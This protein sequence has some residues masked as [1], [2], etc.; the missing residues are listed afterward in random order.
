VRKKIALSLVVACAAIA[1]ARCDSVYDV[2]ITMSDAAAARAFGCSD[3]SGLLL[4]RLYGKPVTIVIDVIELGTEV[5]SCRGTEIYDY[6]ATHE[7]KLFK[8]DCHQVTVTQPSSFGDALAQ[9]FAQLRKEDAGISQIPTDQTIIVKLVATAEPLAGCPVETLD[10]TQVGGC[11][12][13]CP[14]KLAASGTLDLDLDSLF[15]SCAPVVESCAIFPQE[16]ADF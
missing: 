6:C 9:T 2:T 14:T 16:S 7:C 12:Y 13:S 11:A 5:V 10:P 4:S 3:D 1:V 8:R 15:S